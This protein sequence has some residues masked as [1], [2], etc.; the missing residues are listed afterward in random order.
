MAFKSGKILRMNKFID[1]EDNR[2]LILKL[3]HGMMVGPI[4]SIP[5]LEQVI[6]DLKNYVDGIVISP[7]QVN[8]L[9]EHFKGKG[10]P[11][12]LVRAD[13]TNLFRNEHFPFKPQKIEVVTVATAFDALTLGAYAIVSFFFVGYDDDEDEALNMNTIASLAR[14]GEKLGIPLLVEAMPIGS[15]VTSTN[16]VECADLAMRM[17][18]EA[19]ADAVAVPY[20]GSIESF[21]QIVG[22][23][24]VPIFTLDF[25]NTKKDAIEIAYDAIEAG[26]VGMVISF[27]TLQKP[28]LITVLA[29]LRDIIHD[30]NRV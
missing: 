22:A 17:A 2:S 21:K 27:K 30:K 24:K 6:R 8:K 16:Y 20:T 15:R 26:A 7:G 18:I 25:G 13:W 12:L 19:G 14:E 5:K 1:P 10:S 3:D 11:A 29:K 9:I 23:A 4:P 28:N